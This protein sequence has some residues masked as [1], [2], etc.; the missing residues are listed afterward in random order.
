MFGCAC[1][2]RLSVRSGSRGS[3]TLECE[4]E[5]HGDHTGTDT[6]PPPPPYASTAL[7]QHGLYCEGERN[8][9]AGGMPGVTAIVG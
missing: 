4:H 1:G 3:C 5:G 7:S 8:F 9:P 2:K 6:V